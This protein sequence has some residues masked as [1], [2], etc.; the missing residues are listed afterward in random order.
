MTVARVVRDEMAKQHIPGS[1]TI[2]LTLRTKDQT[3]DLTSIRPINRLNP[4]F[5]GVTAVYALW[6]VKSRSFL[7][8][9]NT[10]KARS[11]T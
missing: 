9:R 6:E 2:L 11:F 4:P 8:G 3:L 1:D 10:S 7:H 5:A